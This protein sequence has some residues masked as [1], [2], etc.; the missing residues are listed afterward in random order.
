[1][2]KRVDATRSADRVSD[3]TTLVDSVRG[4]AAT[5]G[6]GSE[7]ALADKLNVKRHQLRRALKVL[8]NNGEIA[9]AEPKRKALDARNGESLVQDTN[10]LEVV[11]MRLA[12]EPFLARMAALRASP[13]DMARIERAATTLAGTDSGAADLRFHKAIAAASGNHLAETFYGML[14]QVAAISRRVPNGFSSATPS[15]APS[16]PRLPRAMPMVPSRRCG[17]I[18]SRC[19]S[20]SSSTCIRSQRS[21]EIARFPA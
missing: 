3:L 10:P 12:I 19:K 21:R 9:P 14:R 7:R 13:L 18:S 15:I 5:A 6:L 8:R 1:M 2:D 20:V 17:C 11:E 4:L 16:L